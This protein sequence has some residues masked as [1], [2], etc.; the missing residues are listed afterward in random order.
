[1]CKTG[2]KDDQP[3][4]KASISTVNKMATNEI[5]IS[6][7]TASDRSEL[8]QLLLELHST[9][10][11]QNASP[12]VQELQQEND[13]KK[14][15]ET[16][17]D[18]IDEKKDVTWLTLIAKSTTN[19]MVGF[20]IGSIETD[21]DFVLGKIGKVEDWFVEQQFRGQGIGIQLYNQLEKWFIENRCKQVRSDTWHGNELSI[22][23]HQQSGFFISG[24][25]FGKKL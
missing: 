22:K 23:A 5:E 6:R 16:Y 20:I 14:S 18:F 10:F 4:L 19:N 3:L 17:L 9:Y 7:Y 11:F 24:I 8:L 21:D 2:S 13:L 1:L 25:S 15:Y 12:Q